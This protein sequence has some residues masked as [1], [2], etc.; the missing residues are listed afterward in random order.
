MKI[1]FEY[2]INEKGKE[3]KRNCCNYYHVILQEYNI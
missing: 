1:I 2:A 3:R